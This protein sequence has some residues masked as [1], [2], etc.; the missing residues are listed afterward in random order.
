MLR[1]DW[2]PSILRLAL[3]MQLGV[4]DLANGLYSGKIASTI[5]RYLDEC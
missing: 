4:E 2:V 1:I 5:R 3:N